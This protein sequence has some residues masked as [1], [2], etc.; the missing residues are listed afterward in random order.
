[1]MC[2]NNI[3]ELQITGRAMAYS[4]AHLISGR[5]VTCNPKSYLILVSTT[6]TS[7]TLLFSSQHNFRT[8]RKLF[9]YFG[10]L[11]QLYALFGVLCKYSQVPQLT[12]I[13][14]SVGG[15]NPF[16]QSNLTLAASGAFKSSRTPQKI[17]F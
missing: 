7:S 9:A 4:T 6:T 12:C 16:T 11:S 2:N 10:F 5:L 8:E 13:W 15:R 1:M 3:C 17:H 14:M